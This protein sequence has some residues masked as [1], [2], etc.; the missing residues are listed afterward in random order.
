VDCPEAMSR[1]RGGSFYGPRRSNYTFPCA[2]CGQWQA[3]GTP[4]FARM[5]LNQNGDWEH[6]CYIPCSGHARGLDPDT[7]PPFSQALSHVGANTPSVLER[8][9]TDEIGRADDG[10][11]PLSLLLLIIYD[12]YTMYILRRICRSTTC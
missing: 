5:P 4:S 10:D 6:Y 11:T 8:Q 9:R 1:A 12:I 7:L 2:F 3:A